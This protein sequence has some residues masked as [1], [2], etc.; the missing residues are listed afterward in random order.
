MSGH[1]GC[2]WLL[3]LM[4]MPIII[5]FYGL[6]R[7]TPAVRLC[8]SFCHLNSPFLTQGQELRRS[9]VVLVQTEQMYQHS[10]VFMEETRKRFPQ[11]GIHRTVKQSTLIIFNKTRAMW[12]A[13]HVSRRL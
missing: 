9:S 5:T 6:L 12:T 2:P 13:T 4:M 3:T 7:A 8:S 10:T 11:V 1:H